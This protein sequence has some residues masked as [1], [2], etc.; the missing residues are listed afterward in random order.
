MTIEQLREYTDRNYNYKQIS[1]NVG[2][3]ENEVRNI[4][5]SH[6]VFIWDVSADFEQRVLKQLYNGNDTIK[7]VAKYWGITPNRVS[8]IINKNI[9]IIKDQVLYAL[10]ENESNVQ[11]EAK[12]YGLPITAIKDIVKNNVGEIVASVVKNIKNSS[13]HS[14]AKK[15]GL[16]LPTIRRIM[17]ENKEQLIDAIQSDHYIERMSI[18]DISNKYSL[19]KTEIKNICP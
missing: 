16:L 7:G 15:Y 3:C 10:N 5:N 13:S 17:I 14:M 12:K 9:D 4:L 1:E 18:D 2:I 6:G 19:S 8:E 11:T